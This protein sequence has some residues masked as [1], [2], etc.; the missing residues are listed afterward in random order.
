MTMKWCLFTGTWRL[1]NAEVEED[2]RAGVREVLSRGD[3]VV[4]GGATGVDYFAMDELSKLDPNFQKLKVFIPALLPAF[5][6]D[7]R[8]NW[9]HAPITA[10]DID[11]LEA[12]LY[13]MQKKNPNALFEL[14]ETIITQE[15]YDLRHN[16]EVKCSDM[17]YAFQV[18]ASTG[19]QDTINK[20][21]AA[22]LPIA[23]HKQ[24]SIQG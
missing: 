3:G 8:N 19:T 7:Y 18:N 2:V 13:D 17:V 12:L 20:A 4:T 5:I 21:R 6:I 9:Q 24:Y 1:T 22:G 11:A 14:P 23:L 16:D 15:H 10:H